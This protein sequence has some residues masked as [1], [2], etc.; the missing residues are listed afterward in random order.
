MFRDKR[1]SFKDRITTRRG[2]FEREVYQKDGLSLLFPAGG[3]KSCCI[4]SAT[5][6]AVV[7]LKAQKVEQLMKYIEEVAREEIQISSALFESLIVYSEQLVKREE[8]PLVI[9]E[10]N[11]KKDA[12]LQLQEEVAGLKAELERLR[13]NG[14][15]NG[16]EPEPAPASVLTFAKNGNRT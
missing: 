5:N 14:N 10:S 7:L 15:G 2:W 6:K 8:N 4:I 12:I 3:E 13:M 11:G 16:H 9:N 1:A